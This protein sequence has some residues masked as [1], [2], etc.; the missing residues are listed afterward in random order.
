[1]SRGRRGG[2]RCLSRGRRGGGRCL[3]R[4]RRGGGCVRFRAPTARGDHQKHNQGNSALCGHI[5]SH[6]LRA[7]ILADL[8]NA[9]SI[10]PALSMGLAG[11][12]WELLA[13]EEDPVSAPPR[14]S[15]IPPA[16]PPEP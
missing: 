16:G 15:W 13:L 12:H 1:M 6:F 4:G 3:S 10:G 8:L 5:F 7:E 2:G 9:D 11:P 14:T